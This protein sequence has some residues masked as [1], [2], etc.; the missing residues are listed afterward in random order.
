MSIFSWRDSW[1]AAAMDTARIRPYTPADRDAVLALAPRLA[2]GVAPWRDPAG[3]RA[4]VVGWV[5]DSLN[6]TG[7]SRL[8]LVAEA[9][10]GI[11]GFVTA[12]ERRRWSGVTDACVGEL[13]VEAAME[14][15]GIGRALIEVVRD[16]ARRRG[17]GAITLETG[18][19]NARAR[20]FYAALGFEEE[21]VRL[22]QVL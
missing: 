20:A 2:E 14:G 12:L 7:G 4:A 1:Q 6:S 16:W 5:R 15:R 17:L 10:G 19:A 8:A 22:T 18:A 21:D 9:D 13:V 3:V 11:V